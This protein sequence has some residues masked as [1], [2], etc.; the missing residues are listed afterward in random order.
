MAFKAVGLSCF[1]IVAAVA[2]R[3]ARAGERPPNVILILA[4]DLGWADL[5]CYGAD[6]HETPHLDRFAQTAMRFTNAY[7]AASICS[8]TRASILTGKH[9]ARLGMTIWHEG[10]MR[11][12]ER[13][14][15]LVPAPSEANLPLGET[16]LGEILHDAG[17][18]TAH[19][20]KWHLGTAEYYPENQGFDFNIGGTLW[21]A[22]PTYFFPYQGAFGKEREARY[23]PGL[24]GGKQGEYL[25]DRLTDEAVTI[26]EQNAERPFFLNLWHHA[27]HTP[28]EAKAEAVERHRSKVVAGMHHQC[29]EYAA[30]VESLDQSV[31]RILQ[32]LDDL[33]IAEQTIVI[34]ASDNGGYISPWG[35]LKQ[36]TDNSPLRS[37]KGSLYEGGIRV[38][39][40]VRYPGLTPAGKACNEPV[41]TT[42][43]YPTLLEALGLSGNAE[44]NRDV[45]GVS[46][47]ALLK[48]PGTRLGRKALYFHYPHYYATTS[49][50][51]AVR[52]GRWK[53]LEYFETGTVELYDLKVDLAETTDLSQSMPDRAAELRAQLHAWRKSIGA[54]L[55][56]A[57][58]DYREADARRIK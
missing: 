56:T 53:L 46:L 1:V 58:P 4:D 15:K 13:H 47:V 25:T 45:D 52:A 17:Y 42:D 36:L 37:G 6:L 12:P 29:P 32:K 51:S 31:G 33:K 7:A 11:K 26:I 48:D 8:P 9:P 2:E 57:N 24:G 35:S 55:P 40:I 49:P 54:R 22:P 20:G 30:M 28:V 19:V 39:L 41:C 14:R 21:G 38:P 34:F 3:A 10:A 27:V 43:F 5:G 44:H 18:V 23:V 50:V 16:T